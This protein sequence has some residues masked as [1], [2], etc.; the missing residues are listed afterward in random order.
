MK[1]SC[2]TIM[3][4]PYLALSPSHVLTRED[5]SLQQ[6]DGYH[7]PDL[8]FSSWDGTNHLMLFSSSSS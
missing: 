4:K 5:T 6:R 1:V 3:R 8:A 2:Y 7:K